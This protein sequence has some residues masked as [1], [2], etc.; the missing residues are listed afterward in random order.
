MSENLLSPDEL[1]MEVSLRVAATPSIRSAHR[2][3][4]AGMGQ[5]GRGAFEQGEPQPATPSPYCRRGARIGLRPTP[6]IDALEG[7]ES[8]REW[9]ESARWQIHLLGSLSSHDSRRCSRWRAR[10][11]L[12]RATDS[13]HLA[14]SN[15]CR[16]ASEVAHLVVA[17]G[18][19]ARHDPSR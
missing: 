18:S 6:R 7:I 14:R 8:A 16:C 2:T 9:I 13:Q 11:S 19:D 10:A 17:N 15:R 4:V 5:S 12:Q 1:A 3:T